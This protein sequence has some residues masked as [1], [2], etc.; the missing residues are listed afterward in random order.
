MKNNRIRSIIKITADS[1]MVTFLSL[2]AMAQDR[3]R[4]G[5]E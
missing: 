1:I 3:K 5:E 4:A 2:A